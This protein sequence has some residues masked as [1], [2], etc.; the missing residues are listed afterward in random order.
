[1]S[2]GAGETSDPASGSKVTPGKEES[3]VNRAG[4]RARRTYGVLA[5]LAAVALIAASA[6]SDAGSGTSGGEAFDEFGGTPPSEAELAAQPKALPATA[7]ADRTLASAASAE[8]IPPSFVIPESELPPV[9]AQGTPEDPGSPG[10]CEVWSAGY[11]MGSYVANLTNGRDIKDL[12]NT[13]STAY[14]YMTVLAEEHKTCGEGTSPADTL[15]YLVAQT[16]PSLAS[17]PYY[18]VC[19]CPSGSDQC[20]DSITLGESCP[21]DPEFCTDLS[22]GS[23][24]GLARQPSAETLELIKTWI[25]QRHV[26]QTTIVVPYDFTDYTGGLF[27]APTSCPP[28]A[29]CAIFRGIACRASAKLPS[30]CAQHGIALVGYDDDLGAVKIQNSFGPAWGE[31]GYMW[32]SYATFEAIYLSGTIAFAPPVRSGTAAERPSAAADRAFQWVERRD[33]ETRVH[34]IF[35]AT[36]DEPLR[37]GDITITAPDGKQ[38][39]HSYGGHFFRAGHHYVTRHDGLQFEPGTYAVRLEGTTRDGAARVVES[40]VQVALAQGGPP[41]GPI[42]EG[43][44]GTNGEPVR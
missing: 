20:L 29:P 12:A 40:T 41:A 21:S 19:E 27:E 16:A 23:W 36:L 25:A 34:L 39:T 35:A 31:A 37:L 42:G 14:L 24:S 43:V 22:I 13:V 32:M 44:T 38:I 6:C 3:I 30:G 33:D 7:F 1:M 4:E 10:S 26:V 18:P 5:T 28:G 17:I 9:Q 15:N 2:T 8:G 11:A